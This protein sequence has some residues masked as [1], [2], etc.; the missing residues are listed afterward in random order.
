METTVITVYYADK[1]ET[2][3]ELRRR[4]AQRNTGGA[5]WRCNARAWIRVLCAQLRALKAAP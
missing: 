1:E 2:I 5:Y 4:F 3:A